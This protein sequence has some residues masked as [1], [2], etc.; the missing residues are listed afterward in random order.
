MRVRNTDYTTEVRNLG[1]KS[2][3]HEVVFCPIANGCH[4][5]QMQVTASMI[6]TA[7][8]LEL[9]ILARAQMMEG[10]AG[11]PVN[12]AIKLFSRGSSG[13]LVGI[14][15][16]AKSISPTVS[17]TWWD[18]KDTGLYRAARAAAASINK[19]A[20]DD[21]LQNIMLGVNADGE[22][23]EAA[24]HYTGKFVSKALG[25]MD[26]FK[27]GKMA[28]N[29]GRILKGVIRGVRQKALDTL[30]GKAKK[31]LSL[32]AQRE[33]EG[34][35]QVFDAIDTG[36]SFSSM[37]ALDALLGSQGS[38][39]ADLVLK[40]LDG[41]TKPQEYGVYKSYLRGLSSG[42]DDKEAQA[43]ALAETGVTQSALYVQRNRAS[44]VLEKLVEE[45]DDSILEILNG[46]ENL[47]FYRELNRG[48]PMMAGNKKIRSNEMNKE[49]G[50]KAP[51]KAETAPEEK[52]V[53]S[54]KAEAKDGKKGVDK[55]QKLLDKLSKM[56]EDGDI[57]AEDVIAKVEGMTKLSSDQKL[58]VAVLKTASQN[59]KVR[60]ELVGVVRKA[61]L[62]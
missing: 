5:Y 33:Q 12:S 24:F 60:A 46:V 53:K 43:K 1:R 38:S 35:E 8:P 16:L 17:P 59:P 4:R 37:Q 6:K 57:K 2:Y 32:D 15:R 3:T 50:K 41:A 28:P 10:I 7:S 9:D 23:I 19:Q 21:I 62:K 29:D 31:N 36:E 56:V 55:F 40:L 25:L 18:R 14:E 26:D 51:K 58:A 47:G 34:G 45:E 22:T 30:K 27:G 44:K 49:A 48:R 54:P 42:L 11:N 52:E 20:A 13:M 39:S 61:S